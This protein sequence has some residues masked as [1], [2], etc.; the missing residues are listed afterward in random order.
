MEDHMKSPFDEGVLAF[1]SGLNRDDNPYVRG[2][3]AYSDWHAG[4]DTAKE[5]DEAA[6]VDE[7]SF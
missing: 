2:T 7:D 3:A 6:E 4:Y 5:A 1:E